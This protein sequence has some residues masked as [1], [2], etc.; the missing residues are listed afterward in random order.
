[1]A[2]VTNEKL[3]PARLTDGYIERAQIRYDDPSREPYYRIVWCTLD[4][5]H[6]LGIHIPIRSYDFRKEYMGR[7]ILR[8][9]ADALD[10]DVESLTFDNLDQL[11]RRKIAAKLGIRKCYNPR[12]NRHYII[13]YIKDFAK[14]ST[15]RRKKNT[16]DHRLSVASQYERAFK[17]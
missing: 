2:S 14:I 11:Y 3:L 16:R 13:N 8:N 12:S 4:N 5:K 10:I 6:V 17:V 15:E 7:I 1:M 9:I